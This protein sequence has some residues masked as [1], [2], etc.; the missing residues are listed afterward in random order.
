MS[1]IK[2]T[3]DDIRQKLIK[4]SGSNILKISPSRYS[5]FYCCLLLILYINTDKT[6]DTFWNI[7]ER[8]LYCP[9]P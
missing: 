9:S 1:G 8:L 3:M 6:I 7:I 2:I 4:A 5:Q